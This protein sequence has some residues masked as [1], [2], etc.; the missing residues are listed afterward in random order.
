MERLVSKELMNKYTTFDIRTF[1][2][3]NRTTKWCPHVECEG[4]VHLPPSI[5]ASG[6]QQAEGTVTGNTGINVECANGHMFCW[7]VSLLVSN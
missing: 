2:D 4:V 3:T 6:N 5:V 7:Y 1:V